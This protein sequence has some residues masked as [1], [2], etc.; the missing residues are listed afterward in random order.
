MTQVGGPTGAQQIFPAP[1]S[2]GGKTGTELPNVPYG[3]RQPVMG[4]SFSTSAQIRKDN[5][6][7]MSPA[8]LEAWHNDLVALGNAA[9]ARG[10]DPH[11]V[12]NWNGITQYDKA[13]ADEA[14]SELYDGSE[15]IDE[16]AVKAL[17]RSNYGSDNVTF[18]PGQADLLTDSHGEK[19]LVWKDMKNH[20]HVLKPV[21]DGL[22]YLG[23]PDEN[24]KCACHQWKNGEHIIMSTTGE[25]I[26]KAAKHG[27]GHPA[28]LMLTPVERLLRNKV[29]NPLS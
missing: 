19:V 25:D 16:K 28:H 6:Q 7:L 13:H 12:Q 20:C 8:E 3:D 22:K 24:G 9:R 10:I 14:L 15:P 21:P 2:E 4:D 29:G 26:I 5:G 23:A 18:S 1:A 11:T 27:P 17:F